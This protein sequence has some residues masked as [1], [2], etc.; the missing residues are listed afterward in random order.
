MGTVYAARQNGLDRIVALKQLHADAFH[1]SRDA[2]AFL[3]EAVTAGGLEHP[4]IVPVYDHAIDQDGVPF[5]VM[6]RVEGI[7]WRDSLVGLTLDRHLAILLQV[8]DAIAFAHRHGIIHRDLKPDNVMIGH[9][10]EVLVLDW[11]MAIHIAALGRIAPGSAGHICGTPNYMAPEQARGDLAAIGPASDQY[12]LGGILFELLTGR[13]P[14]DGDT[15]SERLEAAI[16]NRL[17]ASDR[18]DELMAIAK[19]ALATEPALRFPDV[20]AFQAAIRDAQAHAASTEL[21]SH[22]EGLQGKAITYEDHARTVHAFDEAL[23]LWPANTA[24]LAKRKDALISYARLALDRDDAELAAHL[25]Q[26]SGDPGMVGQAGQ[27]LRNRVQRQARGRIMIGVATVL[28][29]LLM[30]SLVGGL[31]FFRLSR[32]RVV[33]LTRQ[34]DVA[35]AALAKEEA[36][37]ARL[38]QRSWRLVTHEDFGGGALAEGIR[39]EAGEWIV[40]DQTFVLSGSAKGM[41]IVDVPRSGDARIQLDRLNDH[42][43]RM[44]FSADQGSALELAVGMR[45]ELF[46]GRQLLVSAAITAPEPGLPQHVRIEHEGELLRVRI[47][48]RTVLSRTVGPLP[49][50]SVTPQWRLEADPGLII[51]NLKIEVTG[52][53]SQTGDRTPGPS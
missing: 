7:T 48:G 44:R 43:L 42:A 50:D 25:G 41:L 16:A 13:Q 2:T 35:E 51:D 6:R 28:L 17:I 45:C 26:L 34:R 29:V 15:V 20:A 31:V 37:Q 46:A 49:A 3:R 27:A 47:D 21:T 9:W 38:S 4:S 33:E 19:R 12:Q 10:G 32:N 24:A 39:V 1:D 18:D 5:Y 30:V 14:H 22:G 40:Q 23:R 8:A 53:V 36:A 52:R 11:G